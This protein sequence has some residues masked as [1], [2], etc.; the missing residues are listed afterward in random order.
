[1]NF[2]PKATAVR[3]QREHRQADVQ[4]PEVRREAREESGCQ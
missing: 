2:G 3:Q 4:L 1:M